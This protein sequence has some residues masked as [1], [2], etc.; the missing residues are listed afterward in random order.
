MRMNKGKVYLVGAGPGD[1]QLLTVKALKLIENASVV[2]YDRLVSENI[3]NL[4]PNSAKLIDVGKS[5][6]NHK[7]KQKGINE[8]LLEQALNGNDVIRLKGGD[9]FVFGR[10]G[11]EIE[12]LFKNNV[13]FEV[14]PGITSSIAAATYGGIPVTHRDF[15]SSLH[16]ITGHSKDG[17]ELNIDFN[18]LVKLNGTIVFMM[19]VS[20]IGY[21][22]DGLLL[23]GMDRD[24][25]SAIIEN[26]TK[27]CQRTLISTIDEIEQTVIDNKV[28][29]PSVI[30]IGKV[31]SLS[32]KFDWFSKKALKGIKV[33]VTQPEK[34]KSI[35]G[36][37][38]MELGGEVTL[39]P[40]IET[41]IIKHNIIPFE[42]FDIIVFTSSEGVNSFFRY[43]YEKNLD[44][45]RLYNKKFSC[46]GVQTANTLK[47]YGIISDFIPSVYDGE[48][49]SNEMLSSGFVSEKTNVLLLRADIGSR[50]IIEILKHSKIPF[51]DLAVYKTRLIENS[52]EPD[53]S[54][55][56]YVT[57]TSKSCVDG[58][59][60]I[61]KSTNVNRIKAICIGEKTAKRAL[62]YGFDVTISKSATIDSMT[63][64]LK[65]LWRKE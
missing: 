59:I 19:S 58:L 53:L 43:L 27:G 34:K 39:C 5:T 48:H 4:I 24:M 32:A 38:I 41:S 62:E 61:L 36:N 7:V 17:A 18:S 1:E 45:R 26:G 50:E 11:E 29:S 44:A 8:I 49:L 9:P 2:V 54:K 55:F 13:E 23:A 40:C 51:L 10:G 25:P 30:L 52:Q 14:V 12:L 42:E 22:R 33:L 3:M 46:I 21:I 65:E 57:F 31:C 56:D 63:E 60:K 28:K 35:I 15:C 6:R 20:T 47:K 16:I 37:N 64:T